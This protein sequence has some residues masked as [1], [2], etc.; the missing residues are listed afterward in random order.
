MPPLRR[1]TVF[2]KSH[3]VYVK[4]KFR[5]ILFIIREFRVYRHLLD[6]ILTVLCRFRWIVFIIFAAAFGWSVHVFVTKVYEGGYFDNN[7]REPVLEIAASLP[8]G[9]TL[10]Q[11]NV[12]ISKMEAFLSGQEGIRQ[13]Q[14]Y[15]S[16]PRRG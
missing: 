13:F 16:G 11:M 14:T 3:A 5:I 15:V 2:C 8:N 4:I 9:A 6:R 12:L 10:S 7:D 1:Q